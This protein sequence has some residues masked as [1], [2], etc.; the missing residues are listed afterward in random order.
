[1]LWKA[2]QPYKRQNVFVC[3]ARK[4][5]IK[6]IN[7]SVQF[8]PFSLKVLFLSNKVCCDVLRYVINNHSSQVFHIFWKLAQRWFLSVSSALIAMC[9]PPFNIHYQDSHEISTLWGQGSLLHNTT[10][11]S[12]TVLLNSY[13]VVLKELRWHWDALR[14]IMFLFADFF[15]CWL[16]Y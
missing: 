1:M 4:H 11:I 7:F 6:P 5:F 8:F 15:C 9:K 16:F 13:T 3:R 10:A 2:A 12:L 14:L